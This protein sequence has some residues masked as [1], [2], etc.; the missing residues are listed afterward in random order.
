MSGG[1]DHDPNE[2]FIKSEFADISIADMVIEA[3][4]TNPYSADHHSW[5]YG[6][7]LREQSNATAASFI[8]V[9]VTSANL[10]SAVLR[11]TNSASGKR[12]GGGTFLNLSTDTDGENHLRVVAIGERGWL[13]VNHEFI[14][15]IDLT[16]IERSGD[17]AVITG[18]LAGNEVEGASVGF[19]DFTIT[20]LSRRHGPTRGTL[21]TEP[22]SMAKLQTDVW[23]R[24][25]VVE[26]EFTAQKSGLWSYGFIIRE[27][28]SGRVEA[29]GVTGRHEWFHEARDSDD[30][31]YARVADDFVSNV[32]ARVTSSKHLLLIALGD[33][34]WLFLN[35]ILAAQ[36]DLSHNT[37]SG[38]V[39]VMGDFLP[40]HQGSPEFEDLNV[41]AP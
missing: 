7:I 4:F 36:L 37:D 40:D 2:G 15:A 30:N 16:G 41:W 8:E 24:D 5:D 10:W 20:G 25:L 18:A 11:D 27:T 13:F 31:D 32:G 26:S 39:S 33:I 22:Q 23:T 17:A 12:L 14:S 1:L 21:E 34:G 9:T 28:E 38:W 3:T 29:V 35:D 6:F 19:E